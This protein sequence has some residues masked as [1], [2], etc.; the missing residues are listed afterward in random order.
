MH[1][2]MH[3]MMHKPQHDVHLMLMGQP[4]SKPKLELLAP[5]TSPHNTA[6]TRQHHR[7]SA[8]QNSS[9]KEIAP[10]THNQATAPPQQQQ[11]SCTSITREQRH[12]NNTLS[13]LFALREGTF[14]NV[15]CSKD[16]ARATLHPQSRTAGTGEQN[17][18]QMTLRPSPRIAAN[19]GDPV[20]RQQTG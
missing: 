6:T 19:H 16:N 5:A 4:S 7:K 10:P 15:H 2:M 8:P 14:R 12:G 9:S 18:W 17:A 11:D 1:N 3:N 13:V 20:P